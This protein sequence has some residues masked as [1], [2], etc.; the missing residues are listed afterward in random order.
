MAILGSATYELRADNTKLNRGLAKAEQASR[1]SAKRIAGNFAKIGAAGIA[2]GAAVGVGLF[3]L[4]RAASDLQESTNAVNVVFGKGAQTIQRFSLNSAKAVGLAK[5]DFKQLSAITGALFKNFGLSEQE[6]AEQ[7][8]TLTKRAADLASVHNTSVKDAMAALASG[9]RGETE[10]LR[11]YAADVSDAT[12]ELY[13]LKQGI[14]KSVTSMSQ[15]EKGLLRFE[16][17]MSATAIV[18]GDFAR[19][20]TDVANAAKITAAQIQDLKAVIGVGLLPVIEAVLPKVQ[21]AV[22]AF[23][24]WAENNQKLMQMIVVAIAVVAAL[25]IGLGALL[26][27]ASA[28]ALAFATLGAATVITIGQVALIALAV[29]ALVAVGVWLVKDWE[30]MKTP[31]VSVFDTVL[32]WVQPVVDLFAVWAENNPKLMRALVVARQAVDNLT[33]SLGRLLQMAK[34]AWRAIKAF[35][36]EQWEKLKDIWERHLEPIWAKFKDIW[37]SYIK[38]AILWLIEK[39]KELPGVLQLALLGAAAYLGATLLAMLTV[40]TVKMLASLAVWMA[41]SLARMTVWA[42]GMLARFAVWT[43]T[44]LARMALWPAKMLGYLA[45]WI[46]TSLRRFAVWAATSLARFAMWVATSLARFAMWVATSLA[47]FA[48]WSATSLARFALWSATS[49][50][51][52]AM[53]IARTLA[54][55]M[56]WALSM[57]V[58]WMIALGPVA[59]LILGIAALG[60]AAV[61]LMMNWDSIDAGWRRLWDSLKVKAVDVM[62]AIIDKINE[63]I[64]AWNSIPVVPDVGDIGK[65]NPDSI[66]TPTLETALNVLGGAFGGSGGSFLSAVGLGVGSLLKKGGDKLGG[67]G[68]GAGESSERWGH[69]GFTGFAKGG[70]VTGPTFAKLGEEGPE[71]VVP[72]DKLGKGMGLTV[73]VSMDGATIL[74][75]DDAEQYIVDM[76]DRAVRRGVVLG[77]T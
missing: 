58:R 40:W 48:V 30:K 34:D 56:A 45:V 7:T 2:M 4:A 67:T 15:A 62:N 49:L 25:A 63:L 17:A 19:T 27:V 51:T 77:V 59:W 76:V 32:S 66:G 38:P 37:E 6:A 39:F 14:D 3:S 60:A 10:P 22:A 53:W 70:I 29:A 44:S 5:S 52:F 61:L 16:V 18:E 69:P 73:Q 23:Q 28:V 1:K 64:Q 26:L 8:I 42:A 43:V 11:R 74:Q 72:L 12:L 13:L 65:I 36:E 9:I 54:M 31:L 47:R 33:M 41:T 20:Q 35:A 21:S 24:L 75:A 57:V 50:V 68:G 71:V 46:A 55:F